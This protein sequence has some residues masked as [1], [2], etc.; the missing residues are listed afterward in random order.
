[1][2]SFTKKVA[3]LL[4]YVIEFSLI[5]FLII[6]CLAFRFKKKQFDV[7]LGPT[8]LINNIYH[9]KALELYGY[10]AKT[11]TFN[12]Y[13]ITKEFDFILEEYIQEA[14]SGLFTSVIHPLQSIM[15]FLYSLWNFKAIYI[16]FNGGALGVSSKILWRIEPFLYRLAGI[17]II[18]MPYGSDIQDMLR[19]KNLL[20]RN[21]M[22]IQYPQQRLLRK[23][24]DKKIDLWIMNADHIIA[25]CDWVEYL[26]YWDTLMLAHFA[27]DIPPS[28]DYVNEVESSEFF[29]IL[30]AP[31]HRFIKGTDHFI[32][33]IEELKNEGYQ[34]ELIIVEKIPNHEVKKM[35]ASVDAVADQ[36]LIGW[37]AMFAIEAMALGKPVFCYLREDFLNLYETTGLLSHGEMPI[38]NCNPSNIKTKIK[39]L[40]ENRSLGKEIGKRSREYV[41]KHHSLEAIGKTFDTINKKIGINRSSP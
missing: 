26:F 38:I 10:S 4:L 25:G 5:P 15:L 6:A 33:A 29:K 2:R 16:Y 9:K 22:S 1:M 3:Q 36:L 14:F 20:F 37:Y 39:E 28:N 32:R 23:N 17:K 41:Q 11:F 13:H 21:A 19:T 35:I 7:G 30:H 40:I 8:P 31:N 18:A 12:T 34:V 27:I 24:V